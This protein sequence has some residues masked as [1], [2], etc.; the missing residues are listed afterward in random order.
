[1]WL[2]T[3]S[4]GQNV[5]EDATDDEAEDED[6]DS[7]VPSKAP[8]GYM[9]EYDAARKI[10]QGLG[11]HLGSLTSLVEVKGELAR[12]LPVAERTRK[13]FGKDDADSPSATRKKKA[14]HS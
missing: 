14:P 10:V 11:V 8:K 2:W 5:K 9:L 6:P 3:L 1:M 4:S 12:L 13:L 7:E